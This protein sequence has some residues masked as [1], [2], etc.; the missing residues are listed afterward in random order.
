MNDPYKEVF[1]DIAKAF[2]AHRDMIDWIAKRTL[3]AKDYIEFVDEFTKRKGNK[4][5]E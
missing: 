1:E 3:S 5:E 4:D 2:N